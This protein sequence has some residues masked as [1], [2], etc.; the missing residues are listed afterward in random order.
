MNSAGVIHSSEP[1]LAF[2]ER[3]WCTDR[4]IAATRAVEVVGPQLALGQLPLPAQ[5]REPQLHDLGDDEERRLG[6]VVGDR[7]DQGLQLPDADVLLVRR[8]LGELDDRLGGSGSRRPGR[9]AVAGCS[10][11]QDS[12]PERCRR[13]ALGQCRRPGGDRRAGPAGRAAAAPRHSARTAASAAASAGTAKAA[14]RAP[15]VD[16]RAGQRRAGGDAEGQAG[17]RPGERLGEDAGRDPR[18]DQRRPG[19]EHRRDREPGE[20]AAADQHRQR[21][22]APTAAAR[23]APK[24]TA[25]ATKRAAER[26]GQPGEAVDQPGDEAAAGEDGQRRPRRGPG[27]PRASA[28]PTT[29]TSMAPNSGADRQV[30]DDDDEQRSG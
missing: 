3:R 17:D 19:H 11:G 26:A 13:K 20:E 4:R 22:H 28:K 6:R 25:V 12:R 14:S 9:R 5:Q 27:R 7:A 18:L 10:S 15:G 24:A 21:A 8:R 16:G 2:S 23:P 30:G 1:Q 29:T